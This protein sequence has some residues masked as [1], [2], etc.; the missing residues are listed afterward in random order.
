MSQQASRAKSSSNGRD[1]TWDELLSSLRQCRTEIELG[2]GPRAVDRQHEKKRLTARE[3]IAGLI[4]AGTNFFELGR[5]AAWGMYD[6]WGPA[7]AA[8]VICGVGSVGGRRFMVIANDATVK[9]G[10]FFPM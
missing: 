7:P 4:D 2:G 8:S 5:F 9:A 1:R 6:E 3:R 10:A